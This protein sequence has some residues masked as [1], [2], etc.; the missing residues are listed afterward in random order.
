MITKAMASLGSAVNCWLQTGSHP[1]QLVDEL[2]LSL[3]I[4]TAHPRPT[5]FSVLLEATSHPH[6]RLDV[7][8]VLRA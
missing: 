2:N 7:D 5:I 4:R 8:E 6:E 1:E 3:N